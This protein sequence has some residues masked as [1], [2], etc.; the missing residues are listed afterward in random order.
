MVDQLLP[1]AEIAPTDL[2]D[3]TPSERAAVW[4]DMLDAGYKLVLAGLRREIGP[5]GD[6]DAAYRAWYAEQMEEHDRAMEQMLLRMQRGRPTD[7][8]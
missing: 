1:P 4:F 2:S 3:L 8:C 5:E 6:L 7:A